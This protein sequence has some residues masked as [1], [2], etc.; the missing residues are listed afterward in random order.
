MGDFGDLGAGSQAFVPSCWYGVIGIAGLRASLG[1]VALF[2]LVVG[3]GDH[4]DILATRSYMFESPCCKLARRS[5]DID[6]NLLAR[7]EEEVGSMNGYLAD[8][9]DMTRFVSFSSGDDLGRCKALRA[10]ARTESRMPVCKSSSSESD[11]E[12]E[13]WLDSTSS[14]SCDFRRVNGGGTNDWSTTSVPRSVIGLGYC[15]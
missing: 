14:L 1:I 2:L 13:K 8:A 5:L 6:P 4:V 3:I 10:Y 9:T 12:I 15:L 7:R 11:E